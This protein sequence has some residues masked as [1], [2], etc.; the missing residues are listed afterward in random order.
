MFP[1][2]VGLYHLLFKCLL[3]IKSAEVND[4]I[5]RWSHYFDRGQALHFFKIILCDNISYNLT[6]EAHDVA[7]FWAA[8]KKICISLMETNKLKSN[9]LF[10]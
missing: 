10:L 1:N 2:I 8:N 4:F 7:C 5:I 3:N 6:G 9:L